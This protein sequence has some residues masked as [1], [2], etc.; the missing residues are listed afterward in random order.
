MFDDE[1]IETKARWIC[2]GIPMICGRRQRTF[3]ASTSVIFCLLVTICFKGKNPTSLVGL[4]VSPFPCLYCEASEIRK[5]LGSSFKD[6]DTMLD[7]TSFWTAGFM[8][9][10]YLIIPWLLRRQE[11]AISLETETVFPCCH[12]EGRLL[13][14]ATRKLAFGIRRTL[15]WRLP[16]N[17]AAE[18]EGR[19]CEIIRILLTSN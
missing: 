14:L 19:V 7:F 17:I 18:E 6:P 4:P 11:V 15:S 9:F 13:T 3:L 5:R 16:P 1:K 8:L 12:R 2:F 10:I